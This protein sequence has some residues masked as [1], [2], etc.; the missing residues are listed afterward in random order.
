MS[1][2][3]MV[4]YENDDLWA[5]RES[6]KKSFYAT[7]V[8]SHSERGKNICPYQF[9]AFRLAWWQGFLNSA[10]LYQDRLWL[11]TWSSPSTTGASPNE[12][13]VECSDPDIEIRL[14]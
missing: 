12:F 6:G 7:W 3:P 14:A 8:R 11:Q 9:L 10:V 5:A 4:G 2:K 13:K 1:L